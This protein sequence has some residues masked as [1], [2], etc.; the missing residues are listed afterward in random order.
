MEQFT[1]P[2]M[3]TIQKR[4]SIRTFQP[5]SFSS[6]DTLEF[7]Q[8]LAHPTPTNPFL[9]QGGNPRFKFIFL[10]DIAPDQ[11][12]KYG[13][14]GFITGA[15][16]FLC[17]AST[18]APFA[19]EN[20]GFQMESLILKAQEKNF[21]TC[22]LGGTFSRSDFA[23]LFNLNP[24]ERLLAITPIGKQAKSGR[25]LKEKIIRGFIRANSRK[26]WNQIFF[27]GSF[28]HPLNPE[29]ISASLKGLL[30]GVRLAP[31]GGNKQPWRILVDPENQD[32]HFFQITNKSNYASIRKI[33]LGIA[34]AHFELIRLENEIE[35]TWNVLQNPPTPSASLQLSYLI[36]WH[37]K[38]N[39]IF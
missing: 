29:T 39:N 6:E 9:E 24:E 25:R 23:N 16:A 12:K 7:A 30:E 17:G 22:W 37:A 10:N 32:V 26:P 19:K 13:T 28:N 18:R 11:K 33:D 15:D 38:S 27:N 21:G 2:I 5:K 1:D 3:D 20:F 31:S 14:Y 8:L 36:S 35:G 34:V 4:T